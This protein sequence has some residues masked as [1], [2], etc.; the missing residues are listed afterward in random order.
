[1][2]YSDNKEL[3]PSSN[4][5][6]TL[7]VGDLI[8]LCAG[9]VINVVGLVVPTQI[10][11]GGGLTT[12]QVILSALFGFGMVSVLITLTGDIGTKYGVPFTV[13]I[14]S[15]L[16]KKGALIGSLFRAVVCMTWTGVIM[17]FGTSAIN[18][19]FEVWLGIS[20]FWLIFIVF[21][22]AQLYNAS[23]GVKS[24]S[25]FG[26]LAIPALG[27]MLLCMVFWL[28]KSHGVS[29]PEVFTKPAIVTDHSFTFLG[30]IAIFA[31]GW[32]SE[33]LNG[34]DL[35]R[36]LKLPNSDTPDTLTW[37]QRNRAM[38]IAFSTGFIVTGIIISGAGLISGALTG[39]YDPVDVIKAAF[40][41]NPTI[42]AISCLILVAAQWSTN[43]VANIF[44]ATLILLNAAPKLSF[45][46]A[47]W[48]VGVVS[49][50]AM[51]WMLVNHLAIVQVFFSALLGPLLAIMIVHYYLIRGCELNVDKI[52]SEEYK[53][54]SKE[55][56]TSLFAG[57]VVGAFF[58]DQ[59]FFIAFPVAGL[60]YYFM[61][62]PKAASY[63]KANTAH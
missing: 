45:K 57:V 31:G 19:L 32:L 16:G 63:R 49:C 40:A 4:E 47:T 39:V 55:G 13:Y 30:A 54:W 37:Y 52:Y 7:S 17:F 43:T 27:V 38:I 1:M 5:D 14:R 48:I 51:P 56:I 18:T 21:A 33:A 20:Q 60:L 42:L 8:I 10:Y 26:W 50:C 12:F 6:R 53:D 9:M 41:E 29:L 44:P 24:M 25:R 59:A 2:E 61:M 46:Q 22:S 58:G 28:L 35:S 62:K 15:C 11:L 36:K 34:S 3:C 23:R